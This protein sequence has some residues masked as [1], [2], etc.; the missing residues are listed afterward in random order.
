MGRT[1]PFSQLLSECDY[2][3]EK[4]KKSKNNNVHAKD[5]PRRKK[6][7]SAKFI[8]PYNIHPQIRGFPKS[9]SKLVFIITWFYQGVGKGLVKKK[10]ASIVLE[11]TRKWWVN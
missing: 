6:F 4:S 2:N 5:W 1:A 10:D 7:I 3:N 11:T 9:P 8:F